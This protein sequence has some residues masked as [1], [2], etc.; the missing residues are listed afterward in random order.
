MTPYHSQYWA[1]LLTL[2]GAGGSIEN[3]T[4]SISNARVDLNPHQ[5]D[6][7]LFSLRSPLSKGAILAERWGSG[8][9]SKPANET[10]RNVASTVLEV[11]FSHLRWSFSLPKP[12]TLDFS[13]FLTDTQGVTPVPPLPLVGEVHLGRVLNQSTHSPC[14]SRFAVTHIKGEFFYFAPPN[15]PVEERV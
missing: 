6:A 10:G 14:P 2:K 11:L 5:V 4:R 7:A 12:I 15:S 13:L 9:P 1:H 8:K 3:L